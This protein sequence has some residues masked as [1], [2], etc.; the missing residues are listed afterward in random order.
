MFLVP[1]TFKKG[2]FS[3]NLVDL[4][5]LFEYVDWVGKHPHGRS[6]NT[7]G[8]VSDLPT[9]YSYLLHCRGLHHPIQRLTHQ[10]FNAIRAVEGG[11]EGLETE[12]RACESAIPRG[13]PDLVTID[14]LGAVDLD[15]ALGASRTSWGYKVIVAI[16]DPAYWLD[17]LELWGNMTRRTTTVYLPD[18]KRPM[19]PG[20]CLSDGLCSLHAGVDRPCVVGLWE[21]ADN[22]LQCLK[23]ADGTVTARANSTVQRWLAWA[24]DT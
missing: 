18:G 6:T 21:I 1:Y 12:L 22:G 20:A 9:S 17:R 13:W 23:R 8:K 24:P 16:T 19:L 14:P 15:D 11:R 7:L 10:A 3:K 2:S 5:I 4:Y